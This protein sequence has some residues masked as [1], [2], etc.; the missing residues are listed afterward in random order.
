MDLIGPSVDTQWQIVV[1]LLSIA[2]VLLAVR[3]TVKMSVEA[4]S[5]KVAKTIAPLARIE[6]GRVREAVS[7][8]I[9]VPTDP[10][11]VI[12]TRIG[13]D[14]SILFVE[15]GASLG[16]LPENQALRVLRFYEIFLSIAVA[17][18]QKN[19]VTRS[20]ISLADAKRLLQ[21]ADEALEALR[22]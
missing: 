20:S 11:A 9:K 2:A 15:H 1:Q 13:R 19:N 16:A 7:E 6:I 18:S 5:K 4:E 3:L 22:G 10:V 17:T 8:S 21:A 12:G 14:G